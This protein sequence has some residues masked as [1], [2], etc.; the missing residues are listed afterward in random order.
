MSEATDGSAVKELDK[1]IAVS[2]IGLRSTDLPPDA[3]WWAR[4]FVANITECWKWLT[5]WLTAIA[6][7]APILYEN[8]SSLHGA[9][10]DST[11][12][13]ISSALVML[14]FL[15]RIKRQ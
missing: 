3:P 1:A 4:W 13:Y 10:S 6:A 7:A 11:A 9:V 8:V 2:G 12:H 15:G 5:T 14:I